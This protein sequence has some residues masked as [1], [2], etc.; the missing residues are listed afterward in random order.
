MVFEIIFYHRE[1]KYVF[2]R[3][4]KAVRDKEGYQQVVQESVQEN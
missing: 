2:K 1:I 3:I 4:R